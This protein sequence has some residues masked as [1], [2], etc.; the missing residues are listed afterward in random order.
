MKGPHF[1]HIAEICICKVE[2]L[3]MI[4]NVKARA[5]LFR[6]MAR[7]LN[8]DKRFF[9]VAKRAPYLF[10]YYKDIQFDP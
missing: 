4:Y 7:A 9:F 5:T 6:I 1:S 2:I 10:V 3:N 8:I